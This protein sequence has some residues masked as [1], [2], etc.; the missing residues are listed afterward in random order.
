MGLLM[1]P[2]ECWVTKTGPEPETAGELDKQGLGQ[3]LVQGSGPLA[4]AKSPE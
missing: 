1:L 4:P 3:S 2:K